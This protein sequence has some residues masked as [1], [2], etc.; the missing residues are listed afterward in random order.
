M[1]S[2]QSSAGFTLVELLVAMVIGTIIT[3]TAFTVIRE[4]SDGYNR[5]SSKTKTRTEAREGLTQISRDFASFQIGHL[6]WK[7]DDSSTWRKDEVRFLT[8]LPLSAQDKS[9]ASNSL[10]RVTYFVAANSLDTADEAVTQSLYRH[11]ENSESVMET[12][13]TGGAFSSERRPLEEMGLIVYDV[14]SFH[15]D[16]LT[17]SESGVFSEWKEDSDEGPDSVRI[18]VQVVNDAV[19][20]RLA[21]ESD[22]Q[23]MTFPLGSPDDA[24]NNRIDGVEMYQLTL[25]L[26]P[27]D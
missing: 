11:T 8:R 3:L 20:A 13:T 17:R 18:T 10:C 7:K 19:A 24:M 26:N 16:F 21:T 2:N 12:L 14:L 15:A 9:E 25:S 27:D 5:M 1:S 23:K 6:D 22:W 4:G